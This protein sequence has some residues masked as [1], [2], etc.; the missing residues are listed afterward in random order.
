MD[1]Q[2]RKEL[3]GVFAFVIMP[4]NERMDLVY[5]GS[6]KRACT[7]LDML[8]ERVDEQIFNDA[9]VNRIYEQIRKT[10][11]VIAELSEPN[12]N[13]YYELGFARALGKKIVLLTES[14]ARIPYDLQA[15]KHLVYDDRLTLLEKLPQFLAGCYKDNSPFNEVLLT[16]ESSADA[17][18]QIAQYMC[19]SQRTIH[20]LGNNF[21]I[22][23]ND[24]RALLLDAMKRGVKISFVVPPLDGSSIESAAKTFGMTGDS[25]RTQCRHSFE[26]LLELEGQA[27]RLGVRE[28]LEVRVTDAPP[29]YRAYG[30]DI[31]SQKGKLLFIP[32]FN[33][34]RSS[35][36]P[37]YEIAVS[38]AVGQ[39]YR[40]AIHETVAF[41]TRVES[42]SVLCA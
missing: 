19:A 6:I 12:P 3:E 10:D 20:F 40:D 31:A 4:F 11:L 35:H 28:Y 2:I 26:S 39:K 36:C 14:S 21:H 38:G 42:S 7:E 18:N 24:R 25:L 5:E 1:E 23:L 17:Q 9:I 33:N 37:T 29:Q 41:S 22:V 16:F 32:Y 13:V 15:Y 27:E 34:I 30:F 8:C